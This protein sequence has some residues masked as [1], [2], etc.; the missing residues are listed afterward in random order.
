MLLDWNTPL[1]LDGVPVFRR[2]V[3]HLLTEPIG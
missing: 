1:I 3:V 2:L